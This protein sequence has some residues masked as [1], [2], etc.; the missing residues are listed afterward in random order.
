MRESAVPYFIMALSITEVAS[1]LKLGMLSILPR[2]KDRAKL[3]YEERSTFFFN[4]HKISPVN[5]K[6]PPRLVSF[7]ELRDFDT[8]STQREPM[9]REINRWLRYSAASHYL[10][11]DRVLLDGK[12]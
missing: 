7:C 5:H 4:L 3:I 10:E 1:S 9:F 8:R 6:Y 2:E 11:F 12:T